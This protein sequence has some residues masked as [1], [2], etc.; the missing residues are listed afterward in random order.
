M[1]ILIFLRFEIQL[2]FF[3]GL[4]TWSSTLISSVA[5][6][7]I[8]SELRARSILVPE[9]FREKVALFRKKTVCWRAGTKYDRIFVVLVTHIC[10]YLAAEYRNHFENL[11]NRKLSIVYIETMSQLFRQLRK[12]LLFF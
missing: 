5:L 4:S 7:L 6:P 11:T 10:T 2:F 8:W 1:E 12:K 3:L 9:I